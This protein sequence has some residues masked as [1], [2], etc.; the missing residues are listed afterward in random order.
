[1]LLITEHELHPHHRLNILGDKLIGLLR[2]VLLDKSAMVQHWSH[3]GRAD[4]GRQFL[5]RILQIGMNLT[6]PLLE[7]GDET[8]AAVDWVAEAVLS[9]VRQRIDGVLALGGAQF[10]EELRDVAGAEHL[11]HGRELLRVVRRE[12]GREH[13]LLRALPP[14]ALARRARRV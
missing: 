3:P 4:V 11:V 1:M 5:L 12:V 6:E 8:D 10:V 13:A 14:Q 2:P 7:D 9:L